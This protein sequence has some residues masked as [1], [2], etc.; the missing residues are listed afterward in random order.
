VPD[1]F[2]CVTLAADVPM[3]TLSRISGSGPSVQR[4]QRLRA[5]TP[6]VPSCLS[7]YSLVVLQKMKDTN[8]AGWKSDT[9]VRKIIAYTV[10]KV[11]PEDVKNSRLHWKL[12]SKELRQQYNIDIPSE[13]L[14]MERVCSASFSCSPLGE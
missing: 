9:L 7:S 1:N 6:A 4:L 5:H 10:R 2:T 12:A 14:K 3:V 8:V 11:K 13:T